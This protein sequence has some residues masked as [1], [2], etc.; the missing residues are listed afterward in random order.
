MKAS[1]EKILNKA[2]FKFCVN[3]RAGLYYKCFMI[4][5]Y[6]CNDSGQYYKTTITFVIDNPS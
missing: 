6:D 1:V 5:I 2:S 3:Q 4:V